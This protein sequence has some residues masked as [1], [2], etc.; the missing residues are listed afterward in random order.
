[1]TVDHDARRLDLAGTREFTLPGA[2]PPRRERLASYGRD[3]LCGLWLEAVAPLRSN[4]QH[5]VALAAVGSLARGD[6][7]PLSDVDLVLI[8]DG[9][10]LSTA[11][12]TALADR[13]WYPIWDAG[14]RLDHSVRTLSESRAVAS[15]DLSAAVGMLDLVVLAGDPVVV[16][17]VRASVAHDWRGNARRRFP[18]LRESLQARHQ[19]H[20]S[21]VDSAQP[22]LKEGRGGLR[23]MA[24]LRSL[25]AAWLTDRPHGGV[26]EAYGQLLDV[27]DALHVVTGRGRD[28]LGP[29]D[30][31][32]VAALLGHQDQDALLTVVVQAARTI[33]FALDGTMRRAGQ[34]QRARTLRVGPRRPVLR[35]LGYGLF[36]H[37]GEVVLGARATPRA[38]QL[39]LIRAAVLSARSQLPLA[40]ATLANLCRDV[41][42]PDIPW[43][44][45]IRDAFVDLLATGP[46][47]RQVWE[48]L[49]LAGVILSWIPQWRAVRSRPQRNA[50]HRH[51]VDRHLVET[52]VQAASLSADVARP[53]LLLVAAL[54]HDIGKVEGALDHAAQGAPVAR[55]IARSMGFAER[56]VDLIELLVREHLSLVELATR[57]D[58]EDPATVHTLCAAVGEQRE[59]L[60]LLAALTQADAIA[61]GPK[62]WTPWRASLVTALAGRG[63]D[64]LGDQQGAAGPEPTG[65]LDAVITAGM[66][67][68]VIGAV[69]VEVTS[70]QRG[71]LI[72]IV[73]IDRLGLFADTAGL[74]DA[75]GVVV[76][77]ARVQTVDGVAVNRWDVE[78]PSGE[79]P[80]GPQ[81][82]RSLEQLS[83]GHRRPHGGV[84]RPRRVQPLTGV[85]A[86]TRAMVVP[87]GSLDA[88]VIEVR[89]ADRPG[90]LR[91]I[92]MT[93][94]RCGLAVRS[95]HVA[96]Y[97]GQTLDTFYVTAAGRV[98]VQPPA[99]AQV[100]AALIDA[101]D[102]RAG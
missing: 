4:G 44:P 18:E 15:A 12:V 71:A 52:V 5:G 77:T 60:D 99:V 55:D 17:G 81:L 102:G 46:G 3:W 40:P 101:C 37:D 91:D 67:D 76:R 96:T 29:E 98:P 59:V 30:L 53:D 42:A 90:L 20:G 16:A 14:V 41:Q 83:T 95:A 62:A 58:I 28:R 38:D 25:A 35:P 92:G 54:L 21:L 72:Q 57:R 68:L 51:T 78:C 10:S 27:R 6:G 85:S 69:H 63:R 48:S 87:G 2:G 61:A 89:S 19:R 9:R 24:I 1:M 75:A 47:L 43:S 79:L 7:G 13:V 33:D 34:S 49:D 50:V 88:T 70:T 56:D 32:G 73:A 45:A 74:L 8:H 66:Q 26:D 39:L 65:H 100:I 80:D 94:A 93:F 82:A 97:A 86:V 23:D 36:E 31:D 84:R 64:L 11:D 22:Q